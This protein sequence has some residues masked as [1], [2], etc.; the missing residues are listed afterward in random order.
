MVC[1]LSFRLSDYSHYTQDLCQLSVVSLSFHA[2]TLQ[3]AQKSASR[4]ARFPLSLLSAPSQ[5][6]EVS[7]PTEWAGHCK[8]VCLYVFLYR[9]VRKCSVLCVYCFCVCVCVCARREKEVQGSVASRPCIDVSCHPPWGPA[10]W[11]SV[12]VGQ[13]HGAIRP[14]LRPSN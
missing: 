6:V 9:S 1:R 7:A 13:R 4:K 8:G 2:Q 12:S 3:N 11:D 10:L 14:A 5:A